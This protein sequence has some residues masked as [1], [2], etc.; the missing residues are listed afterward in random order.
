MRLPCQ[1]LGNDATRGRR[2]ASQAIQ[3]QADTHTH[4]RVPYNCTDSQRD[5][6]PLSLSLYSII[7]LY[8]YSSELWSGS[9][10][11]LAQVVCS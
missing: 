1:P 3:L 11:D 7:V 6:E 2:R 5:T 4:T 10:D 9:E 8:K